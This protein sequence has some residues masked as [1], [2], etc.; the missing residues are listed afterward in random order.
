M[1]LAIDHRAQLEAIADRL[2]APRERINAL[3]GARRSRRPRRLPDGRP[4]FGMLLDE[5]YG[6]E[7]L[8]AAAK[9]PFW[10]GRPVE[11][12]GSRP[13]R[14]EFDQD[15]GDRLAEWPVTHT[16]KCLAFFHPDDD[17][18]AQGR[19]DRDA[20]HALRGGAAERARAAGRDHRQPPRP[21]RRRHHRRACSRS[22]TRAGIKPD[23]WK[24]EPQAS[25]AAWRAVEK[26][27]RE[28]RPVVP[29]RRP[30]RPRSAG[31]RARGGLRRRRG[32]API[33]KGFAVGRTIFNEAAEKWLAGEID[34]AAAVDDMADRFA[35]LTR[36]WQ[37]VHG[38]RAA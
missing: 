23:W 8:F 3:Q 17:A 15:I 32:N 25:A 21:A 34:D 37:R 27:I 38:A 20:A 1:A 18:G 16:I 14:F 10:I 6:R 35:R 19:A 29:R 31:S 5:T 12:P 4:G 11:Q 33:V 2:G 13:L 9:L 24:L 28:Q 22:S 7:A 30:P 36:A 26:A